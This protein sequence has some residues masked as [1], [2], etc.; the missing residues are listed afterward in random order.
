MERGEVQGDG[1]AR[2]SSWK[3]T[4]PDWVRD[5]KIIALVQIGLKKDDDLPNVPLL[6]EL[7]RNDEERKMFEFISQPIAMQQPFVGP[8]GIPADR[9]NLLRRGFDA[10]TRD[11]EFRK[12]VANFDLE[13]DPVSGEEVQKIVQA[14]VNTPVDIVQKVQAA[15]A[16]NKD[17]PK[18]PGARG[19][20][21]A[22]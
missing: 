10:M 8:P 4:K 20:G 6:T 11:P 1:S 3:S 17:G 12:E 22:E 14:I 16:V 2:W 21:G 15:T 7:A 9:L 13:L 19:G 5:Q 18:A